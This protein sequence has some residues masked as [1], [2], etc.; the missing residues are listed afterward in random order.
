MHKGIRDKYT[1]D[2]LTSVIT[3]TE[4]LLFLICEF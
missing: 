2:T 1:R 3:I 4:K